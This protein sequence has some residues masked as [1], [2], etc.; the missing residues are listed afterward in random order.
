MDDALGRVARGDVERIAVVLEDAVVELG[1]VRRVL[2]RQDDDIAA[3]TAHDQFGD[4]LLAA[5][6]VLDV[7]RQPVDL[8]R[9]GLVD[10]HLVDQVQATLEVQPQ[11]ESAW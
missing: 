5:Q 7:G 3:L 9:D 11:L 4:A 1:A 8:V 2:E 10:V 6:L